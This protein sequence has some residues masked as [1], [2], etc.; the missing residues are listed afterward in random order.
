MPCVIDRATPNDFD[1]VWQ[2]YADVCEH[3]ALDVYG[4]SWKLGVY[5]TQDDIGDHLETGELFVGRS[6]GRIVAAFALMDH[7]DPEYADVPWPSGAAG[8]EV[9][10]VHL[11]AVHPSMRGRH[12]GVELVREAVR[13]A[14][15]AGKRAIH[16]DVMPG[17][18]PASRL[19][20][21]EGF[22]HVGSHPVYYEDTG[23]IELE[24]Y[25]LVLR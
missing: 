24:L 15:D 13:R 2:L 23:T 17:N 5:P 19:Y 21:R 14:Q 7:E 20:L 9:C 22:A 4:P 12:V 11:V 3:Q 10:V 1:E 8:E 16:L 6:K 25:E 18:L